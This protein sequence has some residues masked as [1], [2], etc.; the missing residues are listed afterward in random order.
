MARTTTKDLLEILEQIR[1]QLSE[2]TNRVDALEGKKAV[3]AEPVAAHEP[4][5]TQPE[6]EP[7]PISEEILAAISACVG[8]FL[9]ERVHIRQIRLLASPAWAQQGRVS[10]QASHRLH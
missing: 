3:A 9:G 7:E 2:L 1:G 4:A 5:A 10:V 8:A 6:P